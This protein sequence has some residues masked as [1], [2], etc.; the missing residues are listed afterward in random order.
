MAKAE[1]VAQASRSVIPSRPD[2]NRNWVERFEAEEPKGP[3]LRMPVIAGLVAIIGGVGGLAGWAFAA[4]LDSAAIANA[5]VIVDSKRKTV[6]HLEGGILEKLLVQEGD[7]VRVGQP[8]L[9]LDGTRAKSELEQLRARRLGLEARLVRLRAEQGGLTE[10]DFPA[11][12]DE[13]PSPIASAVV[14]AERNVFQARR[15][16]FRRR[17]EIQQKTV[18][19]QN[20][21][22]TAIKAQTEA[23]TR[24]ADLLAREISAVSG[25]VEKGYAPRPRLTELQTRESELVGRAAEL[26]GRKAKAEQA[27]SAA[28]LEI[29]S[30]GN[31]FQQQVASDLQTSQLELADTMERISAAGDVLKRVIV[32]SPQNGVITDIRT[33]TPGGVIGAGQAILDIV[34]E[35][36]PL[37]VEAKVGL[38]DIDSVR[39]GAPVQVRLTA[40][41][42]RSTHPLTGEVTYLSADQQIDERN[43]SAFYIARASISPES[44][45]AN[46]DVRLYPGMS[47]EVLIIN[48]PRR[49]IDYLLSPITESFNRSFREE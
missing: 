13:S 44:L 11:T 29:L 37:I 16:M 19:Q 3:S 32:V 17:V 15:E 41:N 47:A 31:D 9:Q 34:P 18:E 21:E 36:E 6:S 5:T 7:V 8:L 38:R 24:Q 12:L 2:D 49:A 26:V 10:L 14:T 30:L 39:T 25:L 45:A 46:P 43:D 23:N 20:A 22:L 40:Y 4:H 27:R 35:H 33:R 1:I 48:K 28:E 42:N